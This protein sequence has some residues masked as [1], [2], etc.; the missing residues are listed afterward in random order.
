M[1]NDIKILV[2]YILR[3]IEIIDIKK[4][5][6]KKIWNYEEEELLSPIENLHLYNESYCSYLDSYYSDGYYID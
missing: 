3:D 2:L 5:I 6:W 1:T 4:I